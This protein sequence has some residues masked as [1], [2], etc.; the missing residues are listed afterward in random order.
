MTK[1]ALLLTLLT[2]SAWAGP[3][4][5][6]FAIDAT[7]KITVAAAGVSAINAQTGNVTYTLTVQATNA[8]GSSSGTATILAKPPI[9]PP[10]VTNG[11]YTVQAPVTVGQTVGIMTATGNPTSWS[12]T[13]STISA[14]AAPVVQ[15][16]NL[17]VAN[18]VTSGQLLGTV[19]AT[20]N[21]TAWAITAAS[22][23]G[24]AGYVALDNTGK[25]TVTPTGASYINAL[26]TEEIATLTV[27]ASNAA[28]SGVGSVVCD[29]G[30]AP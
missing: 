15:N 30:P 11:N 9:P 23:A 16:L 10:T 13:N 20:N 21:P 24:Y 14:S 25:L 5:T 2:T 27:Q 7:G 8:G 18:P 17:N 6:Y 28:G 4:D 29:P 22:P 26:T 12:I 1:L 19:T 3:A